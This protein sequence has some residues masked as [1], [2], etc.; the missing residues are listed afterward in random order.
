MAGRSIE[1]VNFGNQSGDV[2]KTF[3]GTE[4]N[5]VSAQER[6]KGSKVSNDTG[7]VKI[8]SDP[9]DKPPPAAIKEGSF[10]SR[11]ASNFAQN[12]DW[13]DGKHDYY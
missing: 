2:K 8:P 10:V 11:F 9:F 6:G 13:E 3:G 4:G 5:R 12:W 7:G 1:S